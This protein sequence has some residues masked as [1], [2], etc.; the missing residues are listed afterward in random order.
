MG[1][2]GVAAATSSVEP[3]GVCGAGEIGPV[4]YGDTSFDLYPSDFYTTD[5][6]GSTNLWDASVGPRSTFESFYAYDPG[7]LAGTSLPLNTDLDFATHVDQLPAEMLPYVEPVRIL[8]LERGIPVTFRVTQAVTAEGVTMPQFVFLRGD[9]EPMFTRTG[10]PGGSGG[11]GGPSGPTGI[12]YTVPLLGVGAAV[13]AYDQLLVEELVQEGLVASELR[14]PVTFGSYLAT[15]TILHRAGMVKTSPTAA[16]RSMPTFFGFQLIASSLLS[17]ADHGV[18]AVNDPDNEDCVAMRERD[19]PWLRQGATFTLAATPYVLARSYPSLAQALK[20]TGTGRGGLQLAG[21]T[22]GAALM[23][24]SVLAARILGWIGII[25][26]VS[27]VGTYGVSRVIHRTDHGRRNWDFMRLCQDIY[28]Q[29]RMGSV[30]AGGLGTF[31][32]AGDGGLSLFSGSYWDGYKSEIVRIRDE[33]LGQSRGFGTMVENVAIASFA[34]HAV[35]EETGECLADESRQAV[36]E[37]RTA[38]PTDYHWVIDWDAIEADLERGFGEIEGIDNGYYLVDTYTGSLD[39]PTGKLLSVISADGDLVSATENGETVN[40]RERLRRYLLKSLEQRVAALDQQIYER[41]LEENVFQLIDGRLV[42]IDDP[43]YAEQQRFFM[44]GADG[45]A[46]GPDDV[47]NKPG[48][49]EL[50][51]F[52][53][54]YAYMLLQALESDQNN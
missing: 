2:D 12:G 7:M 47:D 21:L 20:T 22:R 29:E 17:A 24:L 8:A 27:R 46:A 54:A 18:C 30:V 51:A 16:M 33:Y 39:R 28:N 34:E 25:D 37:R 14:T 36:V 13:I 41:S 4:C 44:F 31:V 32:T 1:A 23:K 10:G 48:E 6:N 43:Q 45:P 52:E 15:H 40:G 3:T 26:I 5:W 35:A 38:V 19:K 42:K 50:L 9:A 53:R 49:G 11:K